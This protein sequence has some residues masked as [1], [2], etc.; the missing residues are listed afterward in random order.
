VDQKHSSLFQSIAEGIKN[1]KARD[2]KVSREC[3][4]VLDEIIRPAIEQAEKEIAKTAGE[5]M[6]GEQRP[7][8][9]VSTS[10]IRFTCRGSSVEIKIN[11][12]GAS[13]I[14]DIEIG[15]ISEG[16]VVDKIARFFRRVYDLA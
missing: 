13:T 8:I 1:R 3:M 6:P 16:L 12:N 5:F 9:R 2:K 14:D 11:V 15:D 4:A 10:E 7:C